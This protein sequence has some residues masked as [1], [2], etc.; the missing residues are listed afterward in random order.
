MCTATGWVCGER[1]EFVFEGKELG[2]CKGVLLLFFEQALFVIVHGDT[3]PD[4]QNGDG[5]KGDDNDLSTHLQNQCLEVGEFFDAV[6]DAFASKPTLVDAAK[7]EM[8]CAKARS[9]V[10][11]QCT[12]F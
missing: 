4:A 3:H 12:D 7:W 9:V 8:F 1:V 6:F 5:G 11:S 2:L 10:D